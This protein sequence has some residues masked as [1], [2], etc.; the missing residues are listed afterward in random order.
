M[1]LITTENIYNI[2]K[3]ELRRRMP[4]KLLIGITK[5]MLGSKDDFVL[6][7][8]KEHDIRFLA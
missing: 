8:K 3:D 2:K 1:L 6:H 7:F 5:S 4:L